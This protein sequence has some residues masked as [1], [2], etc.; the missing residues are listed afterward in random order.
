MCIIFIVSFRILH[1]LIFKMV[2]KKYPQNDKSISEFKIYLHPVWAL[3]VQ[4]ALSCRD[5]DVKLV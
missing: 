1:K 3:E 2:K 4:K 5:N